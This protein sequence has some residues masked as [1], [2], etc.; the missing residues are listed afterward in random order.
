M[1]YDAFKKE[2]SMEHKKQRQGKEY[3]SGHIRRWE[4]SGTSRRQYCIGE[5]ISYWTFREWQK[6][7]SEETT[8]ERNLIQLPQEAYHSVEKVEP[9]VELSLPGNI[10]IRINKGF[11]GELLRSLLHELGVR[12]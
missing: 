12:P 9:T 8:S 7:L 4:S 10:T 5:G 6:R 1:C 2:A 11:D 3:W